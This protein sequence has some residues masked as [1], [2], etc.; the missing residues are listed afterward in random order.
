MGLGLQAVLFG[1][2]VG[3]GE[4]LLLGDINKRIADSERS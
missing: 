1:E 2:G 4:K 3:I